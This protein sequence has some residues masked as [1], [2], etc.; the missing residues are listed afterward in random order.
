MFLIFKVHPNII[1]KIH[2]TEKNLTQ[3]KTKYKNIF[4]YRFAFLEVQKKYINRKKNY[5][6][7]FNLE[8]SHIELLYVS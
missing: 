4:R 5:K 3:K 1:E 2:I 8:I 7:C 6:K